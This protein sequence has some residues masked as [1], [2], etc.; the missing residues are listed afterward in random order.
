MNR[1]ADALYA[2]GNYADAGKFYLQSATEFRRGRAQSFKH[3]IERIL[4]IGVRDKPDVQWL[5]AACKA[6]AGFEGQPKVDLAENDQHFWDTVRAKIRECGDFAAGQE[7]ERDAYY[8]YWIKAMEG[9]M[10]KDDEFQK[11]LAD[12]NLILD[13]KR[14]RWYAR[15]DKQFAAYQKDGDN[16]RIAK[17]MLYYAYDQKKLEEYF[18]KFDAASTRNET[19][20]PLILA[21][22]RIKEARSMSQLVYQKLKFAALPD[23]AQGNN[24]SKGNLALRLYDSNAKAAEPFVL[25][26]YKRY[27]NQDLAYWDELGYWFFR[28]T[29]AFDTEAAKRGLPM[30]D[31]CTKIPEY[32][33]RAYWM[34]GDMLKMLGQIDEAIAAYRATDDMP[35]NLF[36]IA[37]CLVKQGKH[38]AAVSELSQIEGSGAFPREAPKAA[39][40]IANIWNAA[41]QKQLYVGALTTLIG[42]YPASRESSEAHRALEAMGLS[43]LIRGGRDAE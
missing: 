14:D 23:N 7:S 16:D 34:K 22:F 30:A 8:K 26:L 31:K 24:L 42:K 35:Q 43:H 40:E 27:G 3:S 37:E 21:L 5:R 41:G 4:R 15:L 13:G 1:L 19:L 36:T 2:Q 9:Q 6:L 32:A 10:P 33:Q 25:D 20:A 29:R 11:D 18:R 28:A 39:M 17:W 38:A 12:F